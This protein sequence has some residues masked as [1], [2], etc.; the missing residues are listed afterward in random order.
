MLFGDLGNDTI[1]G[2]GGRDVL[3]GSVGNDTL[4]GGDDRDVLF[5]GAGADSLNGGA[6]D[7]ILIGPVTT[8]ETTFASV[9]AIISEWASN[10]SLQQRIANLTNSNPTADRLNGNIFLIPGSTVTDDE[11][12]A[13]DS[14]FGD[15]G[16][17]WFIY[18]FSEDNAQD[19]VNGQDVGMDV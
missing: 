3:I 16:L 1:E 18:E 2:R 5:G 4:L 12:G 13:V 11:N 14:L 15:S 7:D 8:H 19:R 10:R 9:V 6:D 17:D